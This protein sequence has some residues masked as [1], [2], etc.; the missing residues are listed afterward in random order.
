MKLSRWALKQLTNQKGVSAMKNLPIIL[1]S[2]FVVLLL[3]IIL[4]ADTYREEQSVSNDISTNKKLSADNPSTIST[5][6]TESVGLS[7][8]ELTE[9]Q[10][11]YLIE[12]EKLA[13]DVYTVMF[14][15]Y[16]AKVFGNILESEST[17]QER[18]LALL[19]ARSIAD[20]RS[21]EIGVFTNSDLQ[22][23]YD[24]LFARGMQNE[25]EAYRVGV[26]IEETDIADLTTQ[27]ATTNEQDVK[28]T[29]EDLRRGSENH[30]RTFN[31]QL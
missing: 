30:L 1:L 22:D 5:K 26:T 19:D 18:V 3:G 17:H 13:H 10:L 28:D 27:L 16:G 14:E 8:E 29:L 21:S 15:K 11:L 4:F 9:K 7:S 6:D 25:T 2:V 23:F 31:R 20:P 24:G 12:E